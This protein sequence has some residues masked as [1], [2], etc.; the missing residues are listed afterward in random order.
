MPRAGTTWL[1]RLLASAPG[2]AMAG[3]EPMNPRGR[4]YAL[5]STL[6]GWSRLQQPTARQSRILRRS[7][8]GYNPAVYS[9]YGRR[10]WRAPL[11]GTQL[12]IKDPFALLSLPA[13]V[14]TTG[15]RPVI[16]YRHPGAA[17][18]SYRRVGWTPDLEELAPIAEMFLR[19]RQ[20][21]RDCFGVTAARPDLDDVGAMAWFWNT[22]HGLV[23]A[24][25]AQADGA[26]VVSHQDLAGGGA[27]AAKQL[28]GVLG[29]RWS[30]VVDLAM[31][32]PRETVQED[33]SRLHN[34]ERAPAAVATGWRGKLAPSELDRLEEETTDVRQRLE[35][36]RLHLA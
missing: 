28:F 6:S 13:V 9:R 3:R 4:Q 2:T 5:G 24:D 1:A 36:V 20:E 14:R 16:L 18:V 30:P 7:Y 10:Q 19:S 27:T 21:S 17:L 31:Q 11:P 8:L 12:V 29:L 22:L 33:T 34:F 25:L 23:L 15:A 32:G 26:V 35:G